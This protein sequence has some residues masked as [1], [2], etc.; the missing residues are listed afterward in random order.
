MHKWEFRMFRT[1]IAPYRTPRQH[2]AGLTCPVARSPHGALF[3]LVAA[4]LVVVQGFASL[5]AGAQ[6][7]LSLEQM[8]RVVAA[9][10]SHSAPWQGPVTGPPGQ[11]GK[12]IALVTE[13]LR[14]GG[15]LGV[16]RGVEEAAAELRWQIRL[17]DAGGTQAGRDKA[18][19]DALATNPDGVII[20]GA[21]ADKLRTRL[22]PF[23]RSG[24]PVVGWHV[25]PVAGRMDGA[26]AMNV[27][28]D[29]LEVARVTAM[30]AVVEARGRAGVV[31]FTDSNF[32]I[33]LAKSDAMA[34]VVR[35]CADCALLDIHDMPISRS[36]ELMP[37]TVRAMWARHGERWTHALAINDLYFDHA[38]PEL[39]LAGVAS[40]RIAMLSAGDGSHAAF[41]RIRAG[42]FQTATV[43]EPLNLHGW[44]LVDELNRLLAGHAVTGH[45]FPVHLVTRANIAFDGGGRFEYDPENGYRD[46]YRSIWRR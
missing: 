35:A 18:L 5:P 24:T 13:D 43:A 4:L 16:A 7:A 31:I 46:I 21:D 34:E 15:I 22:T 11:T 23:A 8:Q 9:A 26:V 12:R 10:S 41:Q 28:T 40:G 19:A 37:A 32:E 42:I 20:I 44:Q 6:P 45:A 2:G 1:R 38:A 30:A 33:A 14:N 39:T 3:A 17:F 36:A 25:G 27:S 29:P